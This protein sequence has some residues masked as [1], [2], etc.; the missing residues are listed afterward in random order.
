MKKK[1]FCVLVLALLAFWFAPS[2]SAS[3]AQEDLYREQAEESGAGELAG[4]LPPET[5]ALLEELGISPLD[6][7]SIQNVSAQRV[8]EALASAAGDQADGPL[9]AAAAVISALLLC[10]LLGGLRLSFGERPLGRMAG[11]AGTLAVCG[12]VVPPV[13]SCIDFAASV[14]Q[15][16]SRFLLA[17]TPVLAGILAAGGQIASAGAYNLWMVAAGNAVSVL[18]SG[19]LIPLLRIFLAFSLVSA[20]SPG[21]ELT[22]LCDWMA[23][24]AKWLLSL[25][26][27]VFTGVLA[28]QTAL[29][30]AADGAG[31]K[32]VKFVVGS[33]VPVVGSAL[34]DAVGAVQ[35]S[36]KLLRSGV[37]AFGL[38]AGLLVF[39]PAVA[40]CLLWMLSLSFCAAVGDVLGV[41]AVSGLLRAVGKAAGL[42][43]AVLLS[44]MAALL[45][46]LVMLLALGGGGA[47]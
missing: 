25:G 29:S 5:Q 42:T 10:A 33:V 8:W 41:P 39:L 37:G 12:S 21:L 23:K 45:I 16:A 9:K 20:V 11:L 30:S 36:V 3:T 43:L 35:S 38:L 6:W 34:G 4:E 31:A 18:A 22:G 13:L 17:C 46:S 24:A 28:M 40:G 44:S 15:A 27:T 1:V 2:A 19:A 7:E 47:S 32:T 14:I 26:M